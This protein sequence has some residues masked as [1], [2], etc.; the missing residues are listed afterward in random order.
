VGFNPKDD[1]FV[2]SQFQVTSEAAIEMGT[3]QPE[4]AEPPIEVTLS[5]I[6]TL[7]NRSHSENAESPI[8][9]TLFGITTFLR[10]EQ[11]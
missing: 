9:V 8:E 3:P 2:R 4:N 1:A 5:G 7:F 10:N 6:V 11:L